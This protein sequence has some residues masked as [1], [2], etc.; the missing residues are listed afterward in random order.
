METRDG[1]FLD[2]KLFLFSLPPM[3]KRADTFGGS[4][5]VE[6]FPALWILLVSEDGKAG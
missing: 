2:I 3:E 1:V 6:L 5:V 4:H